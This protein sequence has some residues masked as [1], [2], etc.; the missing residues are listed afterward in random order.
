MI[1][2]IEEFKSYTE[3][4][5]YQAKGKRDLSFLGR[6][7]FSMLQNNM[8]GLG[9]ILR[10]IA[11]G[12]LFNGGDPYANT[13]KARRALCAWCSIPKR[14][15]AELEEWQ[16]DTDFRALHEEFPTL[17]TEKGAGWLYS[18]IR[19]II[20][21][22]ENNPDLLSKDSKNAVMK[23]KQ[24]FADDWH[25]KVIQMQVAIFSPS[26][27]S[28][29]P[30]RFDDIIADALEAGPLQNYE[31]DLPEIII[32]RIAAELPEEVPQVI[33]HML[34]AYYMIHKPTDSDWIVLPVANFDAYFG[35]TNFSR[36]YLSKIPESLM[37]RSQQGYGVC[38]VKMVF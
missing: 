33:V 27:R 8:E 10:I 28:E 30:L 36:K 4:P 6:F 26:T 34:Y 20:R 15:K 14:N 21:F 25:N 32:Q 3:K 1:R 38:R 35:N 18:H 19:G 2:E 17:V 24:T 23:L 9:H 12:S 5:V 22:A 16:F 37:I 31:V 7:T 11:R 29:W 13:E